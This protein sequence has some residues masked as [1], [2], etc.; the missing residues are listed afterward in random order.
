MKLN[1]KYRD[2]E[3]N[4]KRETFCFYDLVIKLLAMAKSSARVKELKEA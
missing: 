1:V 2:R 4:G 3:V